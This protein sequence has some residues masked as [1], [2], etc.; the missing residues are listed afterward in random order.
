MGAAFG[1]GFILGPAIGGLLGSLGPR[2][3][4]FTAG[5]IAL[6]NTAFGFVALPESLPPES[7]R[8]F[9]WARA[10]PLGTLLQIR[11]YPVVLWLIG[12]VF[13]WQLGHQVLPSTWAFYTMSKFHWTAGQI[14]Y[15][16]A[17]VGI[18][19]AFAQGVLTRS[20][21]PRLG[22]ERPA[23]AVGM[24][25]AICAYLGYA[26]STQ[27]WMMYVVSATSMFFAMTYPSMNALMSREI[28]PNAQ[29]ELQGAVAGVASLSSILGPPLMTQIFGY[30]SSDMAPIYFP[31]AAFCAAALLTA[32]SAA[33]FS[34]GMRLS[35][36]REAPAAGAI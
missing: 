36:Q 2:A 34:R 29:G 16:L 18:V 13:L 15:S 22:G 35:P 12:A 30:F 6:L 10:N 20:L 25:F 23:A 3:P 33:L 5:V 11:K 19:M 1:I 9:E 7:R 24:A 32:A 4:F 17:F 21:I 8:P 28:P 14:G 26:F 27:G 31:G